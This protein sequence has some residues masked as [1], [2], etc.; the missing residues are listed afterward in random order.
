MEL[1]K[2]VLASIEKLKRAA[3]KQTAPEAKGD[4]AKQMPQALKP[5]IKAF[6]LS[7]MRQA[8]KQKSA[9]KTAVDAVMPSIKPYAS[10]P[11]FTVRSPLHH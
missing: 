9:L 4:A 11:D 6:A 7:V 8:E 1:N 3:E 2:E 5:A 10:R